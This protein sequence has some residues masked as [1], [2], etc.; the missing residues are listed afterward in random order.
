MVSAAGGAVSL[1]RAARRRRTQRRAASAAPAA[2]ATRLQREAFAGPTRVVAR[3]LLGCTLCHRAGGRVRR[4]RIVEVEAYTD[5][6]ASHSAGGKRTPRN[7]LMFGSP[8]FAYVYF[9][10]G[11]HHCFNVVTESAGVPGAVLVRGLD[12]CDGAPGPAR[13]C[14]ALHLTLRDN[15]RDL[16]SDA[17]LWIEPGQP[18]PGE[19]VV[20][21]T[22]VGIRKAAHLRWR[23]YLAGSPGVSKRDRQAETAPAAFRR[24]RAPLTDG[25]AHSMMEQQDAST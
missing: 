2:V 1:P 4:G 20:R 12:G 25:R 21:A 3:R 5:D 19:R 17:D 22:R 10:Y 15:G 7:H 18:R 11:M 13:L 14:R 16:V 24:A 23:F 9:T 8:G 6:A